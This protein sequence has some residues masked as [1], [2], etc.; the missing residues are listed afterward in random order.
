LFVWFLIGR[1]FINRINQ[2]FSQDLEN[3]ISHFLRSSPLQQCQCHYT[4]LCGTVVIITFSIFYYAY[5]PSDTVDMTE[6]Q[7]LG[8]QPDTLATLHNTPTRQRHGFE[9]S[10]RFGTW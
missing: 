7:L 1:N 8:F 6:P 9:R 4:V 3:G 5:G 10:S 2:G